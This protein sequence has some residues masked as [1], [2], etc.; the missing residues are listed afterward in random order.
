MVVAEMAPLD[1]VERIAA[2]DDAIEREPEWVDIAA[3]G[4]EDPRD[5]ERQCK[6]GLFDQSR[7]SEKGRA[8]EDVGAREERAVDVAFVG[9]LHEVEAIVGSVYP[10]DPLDRRH[11]RVGSWWAIR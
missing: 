2:S 6:W 7:E 11:S 1:K 5:S 9:E 3:L 10:E 4:D 8:I